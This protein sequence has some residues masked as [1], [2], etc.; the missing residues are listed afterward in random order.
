MV[1]RLASGR[2]SVFVEEATEAID[3]DNLSPVRFARRLHAPHRNALV[4]TLVWA[5]GVVVVDELLQ[6]TFELARSEDQQM[7]K[8]LPS[9][10]SYPPFGVGVRP[11]RSEGQAAPA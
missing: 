11:G 5:S 2:P 6:H 1:R 8:H 7:V 3:P 10:G 9:H 4:E